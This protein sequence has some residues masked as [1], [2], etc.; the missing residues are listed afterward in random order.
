MPTVTQF[1]REAQQKA[2]QPDQT[3]IRAGPSEPSCPLIL[4]LP[5]NPGDPPSSAVQ[6]LFRSEMLEPPPPAP[7]LPE[8][9]TLSGKRIGLNRLII[10]YHRSR[11]IGNTFSV[12]RMQPRDNCT[13]DVSV[14][15]SKLEKN[16]S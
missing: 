13:P 7:T 11:N 15:L 9:R 6:R 10:A 1:A 14:V 4:H 3:D 12:R 5:Y 8:L 2:L 16:A